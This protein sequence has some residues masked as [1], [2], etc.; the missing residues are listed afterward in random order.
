M[1]EDMH[2][3]AIYLDEIVFMAIPTYRY[4]NDILP[5]LEIF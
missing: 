2:V 4:L 3:V 1:H 5:L